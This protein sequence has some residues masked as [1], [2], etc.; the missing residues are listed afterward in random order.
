MCTK[1]VESESKVN[2]GRSKVISL[3]ICIRC[4]FDHRR[5]I[6][7][8]REWHSTDVSIEC[9]RGHGNLSNV[10]EN[11]SKVESKLSE[12]AINCDRVFSWMSNEVRGCFPGEHFRFNIDYVRC[13]VR[14]FPNI[15][16]SFKILWAE[17][18]S[19]KVQ[20][21]ESD[22]WTCQKF[23]RSHSIVFDSP[24]STTFDSGS[25]VW[26]VKIRAIAFDY[27]R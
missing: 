19:S 17:P 15:T 1:V 2:R 4:T 9:D 7:C 27:L 8:W 6:E 20:N 24:L 13:N 21:V 23:A 11:A 16:V 18:F 26:H 25:Q 5:C 22:F 3:Y 10:I 12:S 14:Q